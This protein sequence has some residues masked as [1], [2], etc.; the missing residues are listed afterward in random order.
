MLLA[1]I[2]VGGTNFR[3]GVFSGADLLWEKRFEADFSRLCAEKPREAA[4]SSILETVASAVSEAL[5]KFPGIGAIGIGFPG[6]IDPA[7]M[8]IASSPNLPKLADV[9]IASPLS[10]RFSL[11]V[12]VENDALAAAFGEH[13]MTQCGSLV[14]VGLGTGVGGGMI[15]QGAPHPGEHGV[16]MEIGHIIVEPGGRPCGCGNCGCLEQYASASGVSL[17]YLALEG[18][19]ISAKEIALLARRGDASAV[20]AFDLA[21]NMLGL[22][23]SHILKVVDI[24]HVIVGGGLSEAWPLLEAPFRQRLEADLIPVLRGKC[25]ISISKAQDR[26]GMLGAAHLAARQL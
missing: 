24:T 20:A 4:E 26:A 23:L 15:V 14:Y 16:A 19:R 7:T 8:H 21:G 1:G 12:I 9:D 10:G 18:R 5:E 25:E 17:T 13:V 22:G 3:V 6:F 2:D 11:P